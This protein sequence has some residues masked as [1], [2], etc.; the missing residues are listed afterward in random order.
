VSGSSQKYLA[1]SR[2]VVFLKKIF[3]KRSSHIHPY[4]DC[5][6]AP[7]DITIDMGKL[8]ARGVLNLKLKYCSDMLNVLIIIAFFFFVFESYF[9]PIH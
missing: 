2:R 4:L 7:I 6:I 1:K 3:L 9:S 5:M 8:L